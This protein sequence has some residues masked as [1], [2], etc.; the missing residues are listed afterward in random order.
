MSHSKEWLIYHVPAKN[1]KDLILQSKNWR[2]YSSW[3]SLTTQ[4]IPTVSSCGIKQVSSDITPD[5][6]KKLCSNAT[7]AS[8][9]LVLS[10]V[11]VTYYSQETW[12]V[13][14]QT[15]AFQVALSGLLQWPFFMNH[16]LLPSC[17]IILIK[18]ISVSPLTLSWHASH[19]S[20]TSSWLNVLQLCMSLKLWEGGS[21]KF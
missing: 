20:H 21:R 5:L 6:K 18:V 10:L 1:Y 16:L 8:G 2:T 11:W 7:S 4:Q 19:T 12:C 15:Y 17:L 3:L 14:V 13:S 9:S